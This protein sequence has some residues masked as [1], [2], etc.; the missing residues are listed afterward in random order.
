MSL[1]GTMGQLSIYYIVKHF[2]PYVT[3]IIT[4]IRKVLTVLLSVVFFRHDLNAMQ[5]L[6]IG[7]VFLGVAFETVDELNSK[8]KLEGEHAKAQGK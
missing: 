5:W 8:R 3:A 4:T 6:G 1:L 7:V 2:E